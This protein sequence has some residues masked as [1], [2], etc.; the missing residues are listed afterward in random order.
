MRTI[1]ICLLAACAGTARAQEVLTGP[2][3]FGDWRSDRPGLVRR[4][5]PADLPAPYTTRSAGNPAH[6]VRR[7]EGAV[8]QAPPGFSV[9]LFADGLTRPRILRVA[10]NGDVFVAET[11]AGR[12]RV[13]RAQA[14]AGR[15][16]SQSVY[17]TGLDRPFGIAFYPAGP[18][19]Q[20]VYVAETNRVLRYPYRVGDVAATGSP[21]VVVPR[22]V[23]TQGG[24]H[25]R[26]LAFSADGARL[27]V[28]VGSGSNDADGMGGGRPDPQ[29]EAVG[30]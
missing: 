29:D 14:G 4:I 1:A 11:D 3:A 8:P 20:F 21:V 17:A 15:P 26:D 12:I 27:F 18:N 5:T 22:L 7:P 6:V 25:T 19:P 24:H 10:P 30:A 16:A 2:A 13:L 9:S 23:R 28:S